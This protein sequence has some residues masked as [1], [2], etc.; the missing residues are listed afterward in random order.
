M[1]SSQIPALIEKIFAAI[2]NRL[3]QYLANPDDLHIGNGNVAVC[4]IDPA[5][6]VYGRMF[7]ENKIKQREIYG[8]AWK[9]ASQVWI[10]GI[11]TYQYEKMVYAGE[12]DPGP[13]GIMHP[14]F[15][16]W[17]GGQPVVLP[18]GTRL[19]AGFS[20]M[21]GINDLE[22]VTKAVEDATK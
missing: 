11:A 18:D 19:A 8:V 21:R 5:G 4:I 6:R 13:F 15:I 3:P 12:I 1:D 9:K 7:G 16:G 22:I 14:E 10:T 17:E 20:G 2:E